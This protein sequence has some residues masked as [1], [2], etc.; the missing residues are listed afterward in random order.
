VCVLYQNL[1]LIFKGVNVSLKRKLLRAQ[2]CNLGGSVFFCLLHLLLKKLSLFQL[3]GLALCVCAQAL[4][5]F[6][7]KVDLYL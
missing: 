6:F 4:R 1:K 3:V 7:G 2:G 5:L